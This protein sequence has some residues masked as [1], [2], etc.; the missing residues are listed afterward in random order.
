MAKIVV[1][2]P[3]SAWTWTSPKRSS[4][5]PTTKSEPGRSPRP[6]AADPSHG[7]EPR[8]ESVSHLAKLRDVA[9]AYGGVR[10]ALDPAGGAID[11]DLDEVHSGRRPPMS[12]QIRDLIPGSAPQVERPP[13]WQRSLALD[14]LHNLRRRDARVPRGPTRAI[15]EPVRYGPSHPLPPRGAGHVQDPLHH[16]AP[17]LETAAKTFSPCRWSPSQNG[18]LGRPRT[19]LAANISRGGRNPRQLAHNRASRGVTELP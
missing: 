10:Q 7:I 13:R 2:D 15:E 6:P 11:R 17:F 18:G 8:R 5:S 19:N 4:T 1:C 3:S 12:C 14:Q 9:A 16:L